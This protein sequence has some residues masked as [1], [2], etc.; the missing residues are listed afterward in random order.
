MI[1]I[2]YPLNYAVNTNLSKKQIDFVFRIG[3]LQNSRAPS[4]RFEF[5]RIELDNIVIRILI[6]WFNLQSAIR[7]NTHISQSINLIYEFVVY[8]KVFL[9]H[10]RTRYILDRLSKHKNPIRGLGVLLAKLH[11]E[12]SI[13]SSL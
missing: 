3:I 11:R 9:L 13:S 2:Q 7:L 8:R 4:K 12:T 1:Y 6:P 5:S 10:S